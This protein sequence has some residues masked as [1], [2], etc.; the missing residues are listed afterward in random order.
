MRWGEAAR[1]ARPCHDATHGPGSLHGM[2]RTVPDAASISTQ[3]T[4]KQKGYTHGHHREPPHVRNRSRR[5]RCRHR[6]RR[7]S[8]R[9]DASE[10]AEGPQVEVGLHTWEIKP[11]PITDIAETQDFD[12]VVVGA[13]LAGINATEAAARNGAKTVVIERNT[14]FSVRG[15]DVGHIGSK[16][17]KSN[18]FDLDPRVAA[19]FLHQ[20]SHQT[21]NYD[22]IYV[23][24]VALRRGVRLHRGSGIQERREHG[25]RAVRHREVRQL[26]H[27]VRP[28]ARLSRC[29]LLRAR[30]RDVRHAR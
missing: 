4:A 9:S 12:V 15:V 2:A 11:E 10:A 21:T 23:L 30:R 5:C 26:V 6:G 8:H 17:H 3:G 20:A 14:T 22:L 18:G 27:A 16:H 25:A 28:L 13:G 7:R 29:R 24:G 1:W 19:R